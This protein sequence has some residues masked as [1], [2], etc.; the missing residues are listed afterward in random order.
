MI[1]LNRNQVTQTKK[2]PMSD[3]LISELNSLT[4]SANDD[5]FIISD[6]SAIE[7]KK[8]TISNVVN[9]IPSWLGL[10][11]S[12]QEITNTATTVSLTNSVTLLDMS[13]QASAVNP[14]ALGNGADGQ[15]KIVVMTTATGGGSYVLTATNATFTNITFDGAGQS[16]IMLFKSGNWH[17]ISDSGA[18]VTR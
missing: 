14:P 16:A 12:V 1:S 15:I 7:T 10:A 11:D 5:L 17:C 8:I 2:V 3:K 9:K 18:T 4:A 6:T 13:S